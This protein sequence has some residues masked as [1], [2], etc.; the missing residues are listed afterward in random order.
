MRKAKRRHR[1]FN[2]R[3]LDVMFKVD[4]VKQ[5][6]HANGW[7]AFSK[8][9]I[10]SGVRVGLFVEGARTRYRSD[11]LNDFTAELLESIPGWTWHPR[12]DGQQRTIDSLRRLIRTRGWDAVGVA[13]GREGVRL[14]IWCSKV[15]LAYERG[16]LARWV[17]KALEAIPD[18]SWEPRDDRY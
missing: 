18:W 13:G 12:R 8:N 17:C 4:L 10:I 3:E 11:K 9:T 15:R 16:T 2:K 14:G 7:S 1:R 6:V 5:Y